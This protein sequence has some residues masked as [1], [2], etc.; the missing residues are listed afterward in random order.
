MGKHS[1]GKGPRFQ[2]EGPVSESD[3]PGGVA[4]FLEARHAEGWEL[5]TASVDASGH[6]R[7]VFRAAT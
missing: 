6:W 7:F 3:M 5:V 4:A 1:E 2:V